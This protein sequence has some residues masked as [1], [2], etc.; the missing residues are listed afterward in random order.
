M[1]SLQNKVQLIT[2]PDSLGNNLR[3]L[4]QV[5]DTHLSDAVGGVH[6]LPFYPSSAD[7]G[8]A[9][10]THLE[11]DPEFGDWQDLERISENYDLMVDLSANHISKHSTYFQDFLEYGDDSEYADMFL[12]LEKVFPNGVNQ[13]DLDKI[14]R[15]RPKKPYVEVQCNN[16][17][18]R[19]VWVS[20]S[21]E[22]IDYDWN[23]EKAREV[24][25]QFLERLASSG[26]NLLRLDGVGYTIKKAGSNS[27]FEPEV[28]ELMTWIKDQVRNY[29]VELLPEVHYHYTLQ[30]EIAKHA[31]WVYDFALPMLTLHALYYYTSQYLEHWIRIRPHNQITTLDT[32]DGIGVVDVEDLMPDREIANTRAMIYARGGNDTLRATGTGANNLDIYQVNCTYYAALN[33]DDAYIAARAIQFFIPGIPQVYY[34]GMLAGHNDINLFDKTNNGRDINRHYYD[35]E[36]I[37]QEIER[38][39][40]KRLLNLMRFRNSYPAFD[41]E[42]ELRETKD[43]EISMKWQNG[44]HVCVLYVNLHEYES[45]VAYTE[46][47]SEGFAWRSMD[48]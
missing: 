47:T 15:P 21:P 3:D 14:Y 36:E 5:L 18:K 44:D 46:E 31:D 10:L 7:R 43:H 28:Y 9:P 13:Q 19:Q 16:G 40:V 45:R 22:Q 37:E 2:Y 42:F 48:V 24:N 39:V 29:N 11:V 8:F 1:T 4:R 26:A 41:G 38:P 25:G 32:H 17:T 34:V 23:S 30:L 20:F 6:I 12:P 35:L 33:D 27:F